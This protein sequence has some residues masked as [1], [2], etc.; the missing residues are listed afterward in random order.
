MP[1]V[2]RLVDEVLEIGG[3]ETGQRLVPVV[4]WMIRW[5]IGV[6]DVL[7]PPGWD[8][9]LGTEIVARDRTMAD[10]AHPFAIQQ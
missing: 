1:Q 7:M 9:T 2:C 10:S 8:S 3:I 4:F 6:A 5:H